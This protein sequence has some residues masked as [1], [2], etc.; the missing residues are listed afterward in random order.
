MH[1]VLYRIVRDRANSLLLSTDNNHNITRR[2]VI[3][4]PLCTSI[5]LGLYPLYIHTYIFY[6]PLLS[7]V[8]FLPLSVFLLFPKNVAEFARCT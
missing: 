7:P 1:V 5:L 8:H 2:L 6:L 3:R 4:S